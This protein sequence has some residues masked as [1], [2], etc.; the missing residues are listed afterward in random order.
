MGQVLFQVTCRDD[1]G[2]V[3]SSEHLLSGGAFA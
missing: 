3:T 2:N 1:K